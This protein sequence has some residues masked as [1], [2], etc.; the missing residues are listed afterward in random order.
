MA[1]NSQ[2][3]LLSAVWNVYCMVVVPICS[4][5]SRMQWGLWYWTEFW[6]CTVRYMDQG[7][8]CW[9]MA[10]VQSTKAINRPRLIYQYLK[11]APRLLGQNCK[12]F[13]FLLSLNCQRRLDYKE[14][15]PNIEV[16][17][18]SLRALLEYWYIER[19]LSTRKKDSFLFISWKI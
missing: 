12:F 14:N 8:S 1:E 13:K 10:K 9:F 18:E 17:P 11:M 15:N 2:L 16:W 4:P 6:V 19:R 5:F 3:R 7:I